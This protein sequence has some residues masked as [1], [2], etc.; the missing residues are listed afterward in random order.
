MLARV[1]QEVKKAGGRMVL[2]RSP[3]NAPGIRCYEIHAPAGCVWRAT[4]CVVHHVAFPFKTDYRARFDI[5]VATF[6]LVMKGVR[7]E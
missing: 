7:P 2:V 3:A 5:L 1:Q 6:D 4:G